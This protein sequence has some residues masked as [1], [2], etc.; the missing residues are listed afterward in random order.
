MAHLVKNL[1]AMQGDPGSVPGLG[2]S[3]GEGKGYL[4]QYSGLE[5]SMGYKESNTTEQLFTS[6]Q[7]MLCIACFVFE[8]Q[9]QWFP[10]HICHH[11]CTASSTISILARVVRCCNQ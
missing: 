11:T 8:Q 2:R 9:V 3:P 5:N 7:E 4:L 6:L 1:P 10:I